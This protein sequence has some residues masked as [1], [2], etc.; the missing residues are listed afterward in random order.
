MFGKKVVEKVR[1]H[2]LCS[3]KLSE[4]RNVYEV[5]VEECSTAK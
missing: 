5:M 2:V 1:T 3:A 4:Q